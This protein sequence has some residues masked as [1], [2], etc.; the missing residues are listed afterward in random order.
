MGPR[1]KVTQLIRDLNTGISTACTLEKLMFCLL[2]FL[3]LQVIETQT[4]LH[5]QE[6]HYSLN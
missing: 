6:V 2:E 5:K 3:Y 4:S 1:S